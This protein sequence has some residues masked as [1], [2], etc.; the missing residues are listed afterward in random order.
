MSPLACHSELEGTD[1]L[2]NYLLQD[3]NETTSVTATDYLHQHCTCKRSLL[4]EMEL[5]FRSFRVEG[6]FTGD[7]L[8][9]LG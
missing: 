4:T 8:I 6:Q 1:N 9:F 3:F 2:P 7:K 5:S